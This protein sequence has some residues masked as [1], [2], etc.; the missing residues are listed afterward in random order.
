MKNYWLNKW[1]D[2]E[3]K[4][5]YFFTSELDGKWLAK[6]YLKADGVWREHTCYND[7]WTGYYD[8]KEQCEQRINS[9]SD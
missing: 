9:A 8:T 3:I 7:E 1:T 5:C 4:Q 2:V 6:R